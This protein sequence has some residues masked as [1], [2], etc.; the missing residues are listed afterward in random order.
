MFESL[1]G[2]VA[3]IGLIV[4]VALWLVGPFVKSIPRES[5]VFTMERTRQALSVNSSRH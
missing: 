3:I 5:L 2:L 1:I 4:V